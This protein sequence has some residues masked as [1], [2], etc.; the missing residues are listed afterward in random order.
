MKISVGHRPSLLAFHDKRLHLGGE[1]KIE[2]GNIEQEAKISSQVT[3][4]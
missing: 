2:F 4:L 1:D 3:N